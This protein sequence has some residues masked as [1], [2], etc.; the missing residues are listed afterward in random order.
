MTSR[1]SSESKFLFCS[2]LLLTAREE[3]EVQNYVSSRGAFS[4]VKRAVHKKTGVEYAVKV[5]F[6]KR[7]ADKKDMIETEVNIFK[8]VP[9]PCWNIILSLSIEE[10]TC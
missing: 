6:K 9:R 8:Q 1:R 7:A 10:E 2:L 5:V 4:V 3:Y